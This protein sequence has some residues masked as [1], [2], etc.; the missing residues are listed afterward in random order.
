M[1]VITPT[2]TVSTTEVEIARTTLGASDTFAY[3]EGTTKY[4]VIDNVTAG[5]LT[6]N[7]DGDGATTAYFPGVGVV[8]LT[9]GYT[10]GSIAAGEIFILDLDHIKQY[11]Q[12]TITLTGGDAAEAYILEV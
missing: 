2:E 9:G 5:S 4:L 7:I 6:P 11:L 1:A 12:G 10:L 8:D 3:T